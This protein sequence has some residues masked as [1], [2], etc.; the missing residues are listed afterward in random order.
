MQARTLMVAG[1]ASHVGKSWMATAIC[2][3]LRRRGVN[4]APFKAQNMSN[5]SYPCVD[6]GEIGRAQVAQAESCGL[7]P[8][9]DMNPLLLKPCSDSSSQV[10]VQGKVWRTLSAAEYYQHHDY[11]AAK[12][13]ESFDRLC[14]EFEFCAD[15]I[16]AT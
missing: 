11:L 9:S 16:K 5:N 10:I 8:R 14:A 4:V 1:T 6:G 7:E 12:V 2:S 3:E 15:D 13:G